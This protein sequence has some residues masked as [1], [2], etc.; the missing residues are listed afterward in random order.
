MRWEPYFR[1]DSRN[2]DI[3]K[4]TTSRGYFLERLEDFDASFFGIS[5]LEAELMDPQ[6]RIALEVTWEALEHAGISATSLA[7]SDTAVFIGVNSDDY[8]RLL[9]ED[10]PGV[11]AWMGIGTAFCGVPNRI[12]Y[13]LDLHGPSTAVDAACA[14]GL[15]AIHHGR[16]ALLAGESKVAI[17]GGVNALTGPGLTRVLDKAGAVTP[18]GRCKSF[19][20]SANG[21]GRGE[22]ASILVMKKLSDA[23]IDG[24]KILAVLKGSAVGQDGKTNGIMSPNQSVQEDVAKKALQVA[25]VSPLSVAFVEAHATSTPVGD[26]CEVAA[27]ASIYGNGINRPKDQPCKIGSVKPNV[28]HL[29]AGAGSTSMIKAVLAI[30]NSTFP[31]QA[32]F[33]TPNPKMD[34]E[35]NALEVVRDACPWV[36]DQKRAGVCSYGYGGTVAHAVIE[37]PPSFSLPQNEGLVSESGPYMLFL[38]TPQSQRFGELADQLASWVQ[39]TTVPLREIANTLGH[40]RSHHSH[41]CAIIA[42]DREDAFNLLRLT[43]KETTDAWTVKGKVSAGGS[44]GAVWVFSGHGAQWNDMGK[45]LLEFEPLFYNAIS[46]ID[47]IVRGVLEFSPLEALTSGNFDSTE[48]HQVL[49]FAIQIGLSAVLRARGARPGAIIGHSVGEIAASVVAG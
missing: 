14:S 38:S 45:Q 6:Q 34:W 24:D 16:Q 15:V 5:P 37:Q 49:T 42:D 11:E 35:N 29:E 43:G 26:P 25:G 9:L 40:H 7:G 22:G 47:S 30:A 28:G 48:Q 36:Q 44:K 12:S 2:S 41:R 4:K 17:V 27:I 39:E 20:A 33:Q 13:I 23:M 1:R 31:P 19:D 8:S 10:I 3:L 32:N 46:T 18:E 21:Y